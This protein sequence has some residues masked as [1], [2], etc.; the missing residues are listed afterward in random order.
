MNRP[1][2]RRRRSTTLLAAGALVAAAVLTA[3]GAAQAST[4][5]TEYAFKTFAYGTKAVAADGALLSGRTA[6]TQISCTR[7]AGVRSRNY[8]AEVNV[9]AD[10]PAFHATGVS[11]TS[12]T[13]QTRKGVIGNQ[14]VNTIAELVLGT[15]DGPHISIDNLKTVSRAWADAKGKLHASSTVSSVDLV[16]RTG[17]GQIDD[18]LN[19]GGIND[20]LD[21]IGANGG[22]YDIPG[23][24]TLF[25]GA[26]TPLDADAHSAFARAKASVL[27]ADLDA[28]GGSVTV[29]HTFA[30][31]DRL[32]T[33]GLLGGSAQ[34]LDAPEVLG[35]I[36]KVGRLG[37]KVLPCLGTHNQVKTNSP[38]GVVLD[39]A[40][41]GL[42]TIEGS[43]RGYIEKDGRALARTTGRLASLTLGP[44]HVEGIVGQATARR[45]AGGRL[46]T[47]T[48]GS[49]IGSLTVNG[50]RRSV[51]DPGQSIE[52]PGVARL[53][54]FLQEQGKRSVAV[55]ALR[56]TLL[57]AD[58]GP[59]G[60]VIDI[61][62][63]KAGIQR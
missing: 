12:S 38:A 16:A 46:T 14:S 51:P 35:G 13:Y 25:L 5:K 40:A 44:I 56:V 45:S 10:S 57:S 21:V 32:P 4:V 52:V 42:G 36:V 55:T 39:P 28:L 48:Q 1:L 26:G 7:A 33:G 11:S 43:V 47:S 15:A 3:P 41:L 29:G 6:D 2:M 18:L 24:G 58:T 19:G 54:F 20:L 23:L 30:R 17:N 50:T 27:R 49:T 22:Q 34:G 8:V 31:I 61:G 63:A 37:H 53:T 59:V 9:P 62:Y 60:T